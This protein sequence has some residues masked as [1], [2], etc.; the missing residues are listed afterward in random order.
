MACGTCGSGCG[1]GL[2]KVKGCNSGGCATGGCNRLNTFDWLSDLP[3]SAYNERYRIVEVSF[4]NG[5]R[6]GFF[7]NTANLDIVTG[8][9]VVVESQTGGYDIGRISLSGEL[10]RLQMRK[11]Q[12]QA[13]TDENPLPRIL[14]RAATNDYEQLQSMRALEY[15]SML[16]ARVIARNL[17]LR[18]K[19]SD[20]EYQGD[21]RKATFYY[22]ADERIDFR[23]LIKE[24][25]RE[26]QVRIEMRQIGIRQEAARVGGLGT[27]GRE[28]C[29]STWIADFQ[30]VSTTAA[31]YQNLALNQSKLSGQC[32][33]LK[34][35]LN[36]ELDTYL[37][38]LKSFPRNAEIL[39]LAQGAKARLVKT[40]IFKQLLWYVGPDSPAYI[41]LE[42]DRV[43]EALAMN[44]Q[45]QYP[46]SL[47]AL[48]F[49][50]KE[51]ST[52]GFHDGV[53]QTKLEDILPASKRK[54]KK[55]T[56]K[57]KNKPLTTN[58]EGNT[59]VTPPENTK[60]PPPPPPPKNNNTNPNHPPK[61]KNP[62]RPNK[63]DNKNFNKKDS[64]PPSS[65]PPPPPPVG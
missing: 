57:E 47:Q 13:E 41:P 38:A 61:D 43:K 37:D 60:T 52:V 32:G 1:T 49:V 35:C 12:M 7:K 36:Y 44:A 11:K 24:F 62:N 45:G 23:E 19:I 33:R 46:E 39:K 14:R 27:C 8:D 30:S 17:Q 15:G 5:T 58:T 10:V 4:K 53:G 65:P 42:I 31:R 63:N 9:T 16:M 2:S 55:K 34:C 6:K 54:K 50:E 26:F 48:A 51:T 59:T 40:D 29:C 28:L 18:M 22:T 25:A 20:V 56:N 3:Y 21:G 64:T